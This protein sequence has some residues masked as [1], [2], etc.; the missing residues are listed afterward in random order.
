MTYEARRLP[1]RA[2]LC[3]ALRSHSDRETLPPRSRLLR[4]RGTALRGSKSAETGASLSSPLE[5]TKIILHHRTSGMKSFE[6]CS[7]PTV[8][9]RVQ[10]PSRACASLLPAARDEADPASRQD[11]ENQ[12]GTR[13]GQR[14]DRGLLPGQPLYVVGPWHAEAAPGD[15]GELPGRARRY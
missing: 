8:H 9:S 5:Q 13:H 12:I 15:P 10:G 4:R 7:S 11:R 6:S 14:G 1:S 3:L 2:P